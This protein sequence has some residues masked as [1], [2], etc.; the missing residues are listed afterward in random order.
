MSVFIADK[1][2]FDPAIRVLPVLNPAE[3]EKSMSH[4]DVDETFF[5]NFMDS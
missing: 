4:C 1:A 2:L 3:F 5:L